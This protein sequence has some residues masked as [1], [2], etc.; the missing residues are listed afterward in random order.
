MPELSG[1]LTN[2]SATVPLVL[3]DNNESAGNELFSTA[4]RIS[5]D[6]QFRQ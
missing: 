6:I 4:D 3:F 5:A 2:L 1:S